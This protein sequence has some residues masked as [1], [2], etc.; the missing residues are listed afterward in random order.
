MKNIQPRYFFLCHLAF[1]FPLLF[2]TPV[3]VTLKNFNDL[4]LPLAPLLT[5]LFTCVFAVSAITCFVSKLLGTKPNYYFSIFLLSTS[6][7]LVIQGNIIHDF[8]DYGQFN[9]EEVNWRSNGWKFWWEL[10]IYLL[11]VPLAYFTLLKFKPT[12]NYL[13]LIPLLSS[14]VLV[15][16]ELLAFEPPVSEPTPAEFVDREVFNFSNERNL[17]HLIPD[18]LQSDIVKQVLEEN[19]GLAENLRGFIFFD[20]HLGQFQGT[21]PSIPTIY[22]GNTYNLSEGYS[23]KQVKEILDQFAYQNLLADHG[24][25]LD[26]VSIVAPY[27][28]KDAATCVVRGFDDLKARGYYEYETSKTLFSTKLVAD[29]SLFRHVPMYFKEKVYNSGHWLFSDND[30]NGAS[31]YPDPV[32]REWVENMNV[33]S[34]GPRYKSYHY[35]GTHISPHWDKNCEY[36][37]K[38]ELVR[39]NYKEQTY[40]LLTGLVSFLQALEEHDIYDQTAIII[41]GDHGNN[42]AA[43]NLK[44]V[45][46]NDLFNPRFI[47]QARP[48]FMVKQLNNREPLRFSIKPTTM[49]DLA[50]TSLHL[51]GLKQSGGAFSALEDGLN[52]FN[53]ERRFH[54]Y[55]YKDFWSGKPVSYSERILSGNVQQADA[56]RVTGIH[57]AGTAPSTYPEISKDFINDYSLGIALTKEEQP[58]VSGTEFSFLI[59]KP[60]HNFNQMKIKIHFAASAM[61]QTISININNQGY[62]APTPIEIGNEFWTDVKIEVLPAYLVAENNFI[63]LRLN[64]SQIT[65]TGSTTSKSML[66]RSI[67]FH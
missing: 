2:A 24:Y 52:S 37:P 31:P 49:Q 17:I 27:C 45:P 28:S 59:S 14:S 42:T 43:N 32:I 55:K 34:D 39:D 18:G 9:G 62:L 56:W 12:A 48:A 41:T 50:S 8:F 25:R 35:I 7:V 23:F 44:G 58:W 65:T 64:N 36:S 54:L 11:S 6:L 38:K 47:G 20:N 63:N 19:A 29:L 66:L 67:T 15:F 3:F 53:K 61:D 21:A 13:A 57:N 46:V 1:W 40:C 60:D 30:L 5:I 22:S 26:F 16:P 10:V 33:T 4:Q 51:V